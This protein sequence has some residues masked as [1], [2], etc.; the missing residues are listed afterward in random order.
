M[1]DGNSHTIFIAIFCIFL[2]HLAA[3]IALSVY[4]I[5]RI[6]KLED[7]FLN[8]EK[9]PDDVI[10]LK[11]LID[12]LKKPH[13]NGKVSRRSVSA[14][15]ILNDFLD[16]QKSFIKATCEENSQKSVLDVLR[17]FAEFTNQRVLYKSQPR[18]SRQATQGAGEMGQIFEQL[19]NSELAIF[20]KYCQN[21]TICLPGPKGDQG[22]KGDP[23]IK[24][25]A[26]S[27]GTQGLNGPKGEMGQQGPQGSMGPLGAQGP[28][29]D[30]GLIGPK[31]SIGLAGP[32]GTKG[33]V[34]IRGPKGEMG[35]SGIQGPAGSN[36]A[37]GPQGIQGIRG[38]QG[39]A[40]PA[41]LDGAIGQK[42]ATGSIGPQGAK[43]E[44]GVAGLTG[45]KGEPGVAGLTG[46]KGEPGE[47]R[48][49][50]VEVDDKNSCCESLAIPSFTSSLE[51]IKI[52]EG[53]PVVLRCNPRGLPTP[54]IQWTPSATSLGATHAQTQGN[55]ITISSAATGDSGT[56]VCNAG[57]VLGN[58]Q[59]QIVLD[60]YKHIVVEERPQNLTVLNGQSVTLECKFEGNPIPSVTWF[61]K[62]LAG[63]S[64]AVTSGITPIV[65]GSQL[66]LSHVAPGDIGE[67]I[68]YGSNGVETVD[69]HA[70]LDAQ[71]PP[72][73]I[74]IPVMTTF[75]GQ[76][77]HL[78]CDAQGKPIPTTSWLTPPSVNNAYEDKDG[79]LVIM[80]VTKQDAGP[81]ICRATNA[82]GTDT[83]TTT[84][85]VKEAAKAEIA[86]PMVGVKQNVNNFALDCR[87]SGELPRSVTWYHNGQIVSPDPTH[88]IM[89]DN[90]L[91]VLSMSKPQEFGRYTCK[92]SD[93]NGSANQTALVFED[94]GAK[95]CSSTFTTCEVICGA[96]CPANCASDPT[97]VYGTS[98]Y[99]LS[100]SLCRSGIHSGYVQPSGGTIVWQTTLQ[101]IPSYSGSTKYGVTS[102]N[103]GSP[104]SAFDGVPI[105]N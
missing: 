66:H 73:I 42:G 1:K 83:A 100:S 68:C 102:Q 85:V 91:L 93:A 104:T 84:L 46:P 63:I 8:V 16:V 76:T 23:G 101:Q 38:L 62:N 88:Y 31:G 35:P 65:N 71:G 79:T 103:L 9:S 80:S 52:I 33:D 67:Y 54:T 34:G 92:V 95:S 47:A 22:E 14:N 44:R 82:F 74:N 6:T 32:A 69:L 96:T 28:K 40:G 45:P 10:Q 11:D 36:G 39:P 43:G 30:N 18:S 81:Y 4:Q 89:P 59:K 55:D 19:A 70:F 26:G 105:T 77:L 12:I 3:F 58:A 60:V 72:K 15:P 25:D 20:D 37:A 21:S 99:D 57:N 2:S 90:T 17:S 48:Q 53:T 87:A 24:G 13:I 78:R 50:P 29:G 94:K 56:Y 98:R 27:P 5:D 61:H 64:E 86:T 75:V 7:L 41:G 49:V 97:A 51:Q